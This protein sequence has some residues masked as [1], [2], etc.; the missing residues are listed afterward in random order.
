MRRV[1]GLWTLAADDR[2]GQSFVSM[3]YSDDLIITFG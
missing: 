1:G 2:E 3:H